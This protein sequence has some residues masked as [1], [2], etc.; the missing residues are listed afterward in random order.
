MLEYIMP[1]KRKLS[2]YVCIKGIETGFITQDDAEKSE[3]WF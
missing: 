1:L 3:N 2:I